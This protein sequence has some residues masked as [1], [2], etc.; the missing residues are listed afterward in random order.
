MSKT[1]AEPLTIGVEATADGY[2]IR[3]PIKTISENNAHEH[4]R[5]RHRRRKAQRETAAGWIPGDCCHWPAWVIRIVRVAPGKLDDDNLSGSQK[6]VR[7]GIADGIGIDDGDGRITW[8]YDQRRGA[9]KEY[10]VEITL[11]KGTT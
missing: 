7:D 9:P 11:T 1:R 10:A 3:L 5:V 2:V 8:Q 4:W 6:A